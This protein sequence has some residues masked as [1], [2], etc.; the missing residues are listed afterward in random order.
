MNIVERYK[1]TLLIVFCFAI[2]NGVFRFISN[3]FAHISDHRWKR[4]KTLM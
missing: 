1:D 3:F 2:L 4:V